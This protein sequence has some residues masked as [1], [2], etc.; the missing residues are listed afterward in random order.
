MDTSSEE[1]RAACEAEEVFR[2]F[3][4]K[5]ERRA[6]IDGVEKKRGI[7]AANKLRSDVYDEWY[8]RKNGSGA[9]NK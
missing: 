5:E 9:G 8:R 2:L 6:Y 4:T 7:A 3:K 1:Y